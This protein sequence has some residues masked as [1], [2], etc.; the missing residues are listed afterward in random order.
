MRKRLI[1]ARIKGTVIDVE[2]TGLPQEGAEV[3][4]F[5]AVSGCSRA[6]ARS[7]VTTTG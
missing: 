1:P 4:T 7:K 2:T 6:A 5:G 3:I